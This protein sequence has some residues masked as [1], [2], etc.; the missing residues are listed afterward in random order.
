MRPDEIEKLP[1][2]PEIVMLDG[3]EWIAAERVDYTCY[4]KSTKLDELKA[5][6]RS[7]DYL[8]YVVKYEE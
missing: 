6:I 7:G 1:D 8:V 3:G 5:K 4:A 2:P